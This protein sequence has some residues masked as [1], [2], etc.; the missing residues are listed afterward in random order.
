MF[1]MW[2]KFLCLLVLVNVRGDEDLMDLYVRHMDET[3]GNR[4]NNESTEEPLG[5]AYHQRGSLSYRG[6]RSVLES[7]VY[8]AVDS[9][10]QAIDQRFFSKG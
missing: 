5:V 1:N 2:V 6:R 10:P 9:V 3:M 8:R 7:D 4:D